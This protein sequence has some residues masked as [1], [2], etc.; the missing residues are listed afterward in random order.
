MI[1]FTN[2]FQKLRETKAR[3]AADILESVTR[4]VLDNIEHGHIEEW[5][6]IVNALPSV[7]VERIDLN[8]D[9]IEAVARK[10]LTP[11]QKN[12]IQTLLMKLHPWRK[13]PYNI[14]GIHI[15]TEWRSDLKWN[16]LKDHIHPLDGRIVLDVGCGSGYHCL[17]A[18][19]AGAQAVVGIDPF[20]LFVMQFQA[21]NRYLKC[22]SVNVVPLKIED[23]PAKLSCFDTI[24]SMGVL[25]HRRDPIEHLE[26]LYSLLSPGGEL[27]LETIIIESDE[28]ELFTPEG[29]YA[30]MR[31]V[32]SIASLKLIE[33]WLEKTGYKKIKVIDVAKTTLEEQRKTPWMKFESLA[34]FLDPDNSNLTIEGHPAPVRAI[35]VAQK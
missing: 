5:Q 4:D 17:R 22:D 14:L 13:G 24:F 35:I 20:L 9:I 25:Y 32:W 27:V 10:Q 2:F 26:K 18:K 31:N 21:I 19:A 12:E 28:A 3:N 8:N 7:E 34:D 15:D 11:E 1:D 33:N 6:A 23:L 16:R 29:R 30:K